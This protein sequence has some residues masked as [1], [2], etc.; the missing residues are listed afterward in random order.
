MDT[1]FGVLNCLHAQIKRIRSSKRRD[2]QKAILNAS[3]AFEFSTHGKRPGWSLDGGALE[4][5][6]RC[7]FFFEEFLGNSDK[8]KE[9]LGPNHGSPYFHLLPL[10]LAV[11]GALQEGEN[12]LTATDALWLGLIDTVRANIPALSFP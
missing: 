9:L 1:Y 4:R 3:V 11:C 12:E 7:Y 2:I 5:I 6:S 8:P 10:C